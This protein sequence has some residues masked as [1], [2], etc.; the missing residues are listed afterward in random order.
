MGTWVNRFAQWPMTMSVRPAIAAWTAFCASMAQNTASAPVGGN[1]ADGVGGV[2]IFEVDLDILFFEKLIDPVFEKEADIFF[3]EVS[4]SVALFL[5][6]FG[7]ELLAGSLRDHDDGVVLFLHTS[8]KVGEQGVG[9]V[10]FEGEGGFRNQTVVDV[11]VGPA[12]C[13]RR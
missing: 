10:S 2:E 6:V 7:E 4:G 12:W 9:T 8:G 3:E 5:P 1:A 11:G 13:R